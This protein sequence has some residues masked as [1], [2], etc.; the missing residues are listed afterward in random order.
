[1][2]SA[3]VLWWS[4]ECD[5]CLSWQPWLRIAGDAHG[6]GRV[7]HRYG[8]RRRCWRCGVQLEV[9]PATRW[10]LAGEVA[11][12]TGGEEHRRASNESL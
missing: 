11:P 10:V 2:V 3:S 6:P 1:M 7:D 4:P 12:P 8:T 5:V 9:G